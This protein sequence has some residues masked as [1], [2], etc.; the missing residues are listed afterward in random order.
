MFYSIRY[1]LYKMFCLIRLRL[2][3][4]EDEE[5]MTK[6][7]TAV[8]C[9]ASGTTSLKQCWINK[10]QLNVDL[11]ATKSFWFS[12]DETL[13]KSISPITRQKKLSWAYFITEKISRNCKFVHQMNQSIKWF[14]SFN[15][16]LH[17][18]KMLRSLR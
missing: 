17:F 14:E 7:S 4:N 18:F 2:A 1:W 12:Y 13:N 11:K 9:T 16:Y 6:L 15:N 10:Q 5:P 8:I 3:W